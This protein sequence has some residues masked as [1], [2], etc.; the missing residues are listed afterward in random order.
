MRFAHAEIDVV[1]REAHVALVR[2]RRLHLVAVVALVVSGVVHLVA[3]V[4]PHTTRRPHVL[5]VGGRVA[6]VLHGLLVRHLVTR[7]RLALKVQVVEI[8]QRG[9]G[10]LNCR[11][12]PVSGVEHRASRHRR[13]CIRIRAQV[14]DCV[15]LARRAHH[16]QERRNHG[17]NG[18]KHAAWCHRMRGGAAIVVQ[19]LE[20]RAPVIA[21]GCGALIRC[22]HVDGVVARGIHLLPL[23]RLH[24]G[25]SVRSRPILLG[26]RAKVLRRGGG[27]VHKA[28]GLNGAR[29]LR[30]FQ[31]RGGEPAV[32]RVQ[33]KRVGQVLLHLALRGGAGRV[34]DVVIRGP[35]VRFQA[36]R[37][38]GVRLHAQLVH[39]AVH[40]LVTRVHAGIE[41]AAAGIREALV[42]SRRHVH[43]LPRLHV[44]HFAGR[45]LA[46]LHEVARVRR[47]VHVIVILLRFEQ[48]RNLRLADPLRPRA[49]HGV[50]HGLVHVGVR[51]APADFGAEE[52]RHVVVLKVGG[53]HG[54]ARQRHDLAAL[55]VG[56]AELRF[57]AEVGAAVGHF[58]KHGLL[59]VLVGGGVGVREVGVLVGVVA[60]LGLEHGVVVGRN[61]HVGHGIDRLAHVDVALF[62]G[63]RGS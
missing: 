10:F 34:L 46:R 6:L 15:L 20:P 43:L 2:P 13:T 41:A 8:Q 9:R 27:T 29:G 55:L 52:G 56:V 37:E 45:H 31:A 62:H 63:I 4:R 49:V 22:S 47:A 54:L 50:Q 5:H 58:L 26:T 12:Q 18:A 21:G 61:R 30:L 48:R 17:A 32:G 60:R 51:G 3:H 53:V 36:E 44:G 28:V 16:I 1:T 24:F 39:V 35:L 33:V 11:G 59:V 23:G 40:P 7:I 19:H 38:L 14:A 57:A 42:Q 25:C